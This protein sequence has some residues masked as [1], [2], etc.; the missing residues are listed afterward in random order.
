MK[1]IN[2]Y[3]TVYCKNKFYRKNYLQKRKFIKCIKDFL[4]RESSIKFNEKVAA[5]VVDS[6]MVIKRV[7]KRTDKFDTPVK[8]DKQFSGA[9]I[10]TAV[11]IIKRR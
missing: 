3:L 9:D 10:W 7:L 4:R 6:D 11:V 8:G 5:I 2:A 1:K